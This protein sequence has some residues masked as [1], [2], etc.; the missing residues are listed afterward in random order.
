MPRKST[1]LFPKLL[2]GVAFHRNS[3]DVAAQKEERASRAERRRRERARAKAERAPPANAAPADASP[4][5]PSAAGHA[6]TAAVEPVRFAELTS[7]A[8]ARLWPLIERIQA[9]HH[10]ERAPKT[11]PPPG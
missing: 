5:Y 10:V 9:R 7:P 3:E 6:V 2:T 4:L 11:H 1:D 8:A